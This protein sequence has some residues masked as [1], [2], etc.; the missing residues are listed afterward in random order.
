MWQRV[1][2][3]TCSRPRSWRP[4]EGG[5][6]TFTIGDLSTVYSFHTLD[7][8]HMIS[9]DSFLVCWLVHRSFPLCHIHWLSAS[10]LFVLFWV[11][12]KAW[13]FCRSASSWCFS[14]ASVWTSHASL[15]WV[16]WCFHTRAR[17]RQDNDKTKVEPVHFYYAFHTRFV[18]PGV[19]GIIEMHRFNFCLVVVLSLSCSGVKAPL[20]VFPWLVVYFLFAWT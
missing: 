16:L 12:L 7:R 9:L 2:Y 13:H 5:K 14:D 6:H 10:W 11:E 8:C 20:V 17:Q 19:K 1:Q 18:G 15:S 3:T 4:P